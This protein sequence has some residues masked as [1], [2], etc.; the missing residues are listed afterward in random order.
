MPAEVK[1]EEEEEADFPVASP[2]AVLEEDTN[3]QN[4]NAKDNDEIQQFMESSPPIITDEPAV[5]EIVVSKSLPTAAPQKVTA[6]EII[7]DI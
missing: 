6:S 3:A 4:E 1:S 5:E 7:A 2:Q